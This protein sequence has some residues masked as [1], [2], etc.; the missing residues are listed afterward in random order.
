MLYVLVVDENQDLRAAVKQEIEEHEEISV[1]AEAQ[2]GVTAVNLALQVRP[3]VVVMDVGISRM[4]GIEATRWLKTIAPEISVIGLSTQDDEFTRRVMFEAGAIA[5]VS[6]TL[7][8][9]ELVPAIIG[10]EV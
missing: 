2:D 7:M 3:H 8:N 4:H 6:K 5:F 10:C 1:V 9:E